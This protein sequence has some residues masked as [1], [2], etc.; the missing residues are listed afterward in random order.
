[1]LQLELTW[2][3]YTSERYIAQKIFLTSLKSKRLSF[4]SDNILR[5]YRLAEK[6]ERSQCCIQSVYSQFEYN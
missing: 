3:A 5:G 1:M 2:T 6:I 4:Q